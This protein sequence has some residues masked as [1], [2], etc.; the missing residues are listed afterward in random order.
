M[1]EN[2]IHSL[3]RYMDENVDALRQLLPQVIDAFSETAV[4]QSR[5]ATRRLRAGLD[6]FEPF[7]DS[8][9][10]RLFSKFART[11]RRRLGPL[12]DSDVMRGQLRQLSLQHPQKHALGKTIGQDLRR[13]CEFLSERLVQRQSKL[14]D[15]LLHEV[16][17][18]Y[19]LEEL[20]G[21]W[22]VRQVL[23][24]AVEPAT[25]RLRER[26]HDLTEGFRTDARIVCG[27]EISAKTGRKPSGFAS[28]GSEIVSENGDARGS[29]ESSKEDANDKGDAL[30]NESAVEPSDTDPDVDTGVDTDVDTDVDTEADAPDSALTVD[31][32]E[33]RIVGKTLRYTLEMSGRVGHEVPD[34]AMKL[35]KKLQDHLGTWHDF[36]ILSQHVM[37]LSAKEELSLHDAANQIA[38]LEVARISLRQSISAIGKFKRTWAL[39]GE[40]LVPRLQKAIPLTRAAKSTKARASSESKMSTPKTSAT[41]T[42]TPKTSTPKMSAPKMSAPKISTP[43]TRAKKGPDRKSTPKREE[44]ETRSTDETEASQASAAPSSNAARKPPSRPRRRPAARRDA[45]PRR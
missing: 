10:V 40:A 28:S 14:R 42:S 22:A 8:K 43:T 16:D 4:H 11:L 44:P 13:G 9:R 26:V 32:H 36:A 21:W 6:L 35:F 24:S 5:V 34:D 33:L 3:I 31:I 15:Q 38:V 27:T 1:Q 23:V 29:D 37:T 17:D 30:E 18:V 41:K 45:E 19:L 25:Q 20:G 2:G 12:R 7:V 39:S